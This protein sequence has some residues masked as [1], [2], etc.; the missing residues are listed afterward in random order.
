M[1]IENAGEPG[2]K[3]LATASTVKEK[4]GNHAGESEIKLTAED[5]FK[6]RTWP[7]SSVASSPS[8]AS[9]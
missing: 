7:R 1:E 2:Q 5:Q 9:A 8:G 4:G 6:V 3:E